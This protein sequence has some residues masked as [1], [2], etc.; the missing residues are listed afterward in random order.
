MPRNGSQKSQTAIFGLNVLTWV[1]YAKNPFT[2]TVLVL[3]ALCIKK[4][5]TKCARDLVPN[6]AFSHSVW[7]RAVNS[8]K[9]FDFL[10]Y[11]WIGFSGL[12]LNSRR[13][14]RFSL[15]TGE[16]FNHKCHFGTFG[17]NSS[18][19]DWSDFFSDRPAPDEL[20]REIFSSEAPAALLSAPRLKRGAERRRRI[21]FFSCRLRRQTHTDHLGKNLGL[22]H[23]RCLPTEGAPF[24]NLA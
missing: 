6:C 16:N 9:I 17:S 20:R 4:K 5:C 3:G 8:P 1:N 10:N 13:V 7:S 12:N 18:G 2:C 21:Q 19:A 22:R 15:D 14:Q 23:R 11:F 24:R